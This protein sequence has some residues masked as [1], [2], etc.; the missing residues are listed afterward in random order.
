MSTHN[1]EAALVSSHVTCSTHGLCRCTLIL[2]YV[3]I[4]SVHWS[5]AMGG[6][7]SC[8][9][10]AIIFGDLLDFYTGSGTFQT[11]SRNIVN[12]HLAQ[13]CQI[14][15]VRSVSWGLDSDPHL[16]QQSERQDKQHQ[17]AVGVNTGIFTPPGAG[18]C[19]QWV[20]IPWVLWWV[21]SVHTLPLN[22]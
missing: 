13:A 3:P 8:C 22:P 4:T 6:T 21:L 18:M 2:A 7:W 19:P 1:R 5:I 11:L 17:G 12:H 14:L 16:W 15:L 10:T 20:S 9:F